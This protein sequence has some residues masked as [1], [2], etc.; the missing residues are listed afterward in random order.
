MQRYDPNEHAKPRKQKREETVGRPKASFLACGNKRKRVLSEVEMGFRSQI[1]EEPT[2]HVKNIV[3][4][5]K[6]TW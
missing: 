5:T 6:K 3:L 1:I 4:S 2:G